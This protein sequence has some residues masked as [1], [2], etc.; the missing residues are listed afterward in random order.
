MNTVQPLKTFRFLL[1]RDLRLL[2]SGFIHYLID[3]LIWT[4][5]NVIISGY[6]LPLLGMGRSYGNFMLVG[7]T[8]SMCFFYAINKSHDLVADFEGSKN[9]TYDLVLPIASW[10]VFFK[11]ALSFALQAALVNILAIPLGKIL[12][13]ESLHMSLFAC[14]KVIMVFSLIAIFLGFFGLWVASWVKHPSLYPHVWMR[15]ILPLWAFGGY[16]FSWYTLKGA[17]PLIA[18]ASLL[19]PMVYTF[20]SLRAVLLG[21]EEYIPLAV[22][23]FMLTMFT[24]L[25]WVHT[26]YLLKKRLDYI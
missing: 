10:A 5:S 1:W 2:R 26:L 23:I 16:Q 7:S 24:L 15:F 4:G 9:I 20:E 21:Q 17:Y 3:T 25:L 14:S 11:I 12:L 22:C 8:I 19:N 6:L 13:G 18:Y